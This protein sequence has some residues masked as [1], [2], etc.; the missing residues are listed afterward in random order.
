MSTAQLIGTPGP[1]L[2]P[3]SDLTLQ[4]TAPPPPGTNPPPSRFLLF[5]N[6]WLDLQNYIQMALA[7]PITKGDFATK[8]GDFP[9]TSTSLITNAIGAMSDVSKLSAVFGD[10]STLKTKIISDPNYLLTQTPPTEIYGNIVWLANQIQ[11]T[12]STFSYTFANLA[13]IIGPGAGTPAQR[14]ANLKA[15]LDGPGGLASSAKL[16]QQQTSA[17]MAKLLSFDS[18]ITL[19]NGQILTYVG[20]QSSLLSTASGLIGK[21]NDDINN[22]L[23]PAADAAYK[24]WRDYTIAAVTTSVGIMVLSCGLLWPVAVG[25][26]VGLGVAAAAEKTAYNNLMDQIATERADIQKKTNLVTDLSGFNGKVSLVAPALSSFKSSL[27]TVEGTFNTAAMNL[28]FIANNFS[29]AQLSDLNWVM[30]T[31]KIGDAQNKWQAIAATTQDYTSNS[32]VSY[33][34]GTSYGQKIA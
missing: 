30:Q 8:Y 3:A 7:M 32:L 14:A 1:S 25:L 20:S 10:P 6:E 5:T 13:P 17:L 2:V 31:M 28:A 23:Q 33:D 24:A 15:I 19:A 18:Q 12:A 29:D 4:S 26:G 16:M 11:N 34:L 9:A 21:M 22:N 27:E